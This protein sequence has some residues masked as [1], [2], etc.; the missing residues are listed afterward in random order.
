V[1]PQKTIAYHA[2]DTPSA[3][4]WWETETKTKKIS[5]S[6]LEKDEGEREKH[7]L[8]HDD[9]CISEGRNE[10]VIAERTFKNIGLINWEK[11]RAQWRRVCGDRQKTPYVKSSDLVRIKKGLKQVQRTYAMPSR[12]P[13]PDVIKLYQ[14]IWHGSKDVK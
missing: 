10:S 14:D 12:M 8:T 6:Q 5:K 2:E 11:S 3:R 7:K 4:D 13:L 1:Y 9:G